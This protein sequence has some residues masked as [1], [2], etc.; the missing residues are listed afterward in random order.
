MLRY[1]MLNDVALCCA[2]LCYAVVWYA[3]L[4]YAMRIYMMST[5]Q[6]V[7][8]D[9]KYNH[10]HHEAMRASYFAAMAQIRRT[11]QKPG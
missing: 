5:Y 2:V 11:D 9:L 3:M 10:N 4:C 1:A 8:Q 6:R 7:D